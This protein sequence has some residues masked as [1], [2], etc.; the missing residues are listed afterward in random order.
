MVLT[1]IVPALCFG[2]WDRFELDNGVVS[3]GLSRE[4]AAWAIF[5]IGQPMIF[6]YYVWLPSA[7][8]GLIKD[9]V[10]RRRLPVD[11]KLVEILQD[12]QNWLNSPWL[13]RI[14]LTI[15]ILVQ[16]FV[17]LLEKGVIGSY[18]A[19][20]V[21]VNPPV[22]WSRTAIAVAVYSALAVLIFSWAILINTI[23]R[24]MRTDRVIVEPFHHDGA[25]GLGAIG[26]FV[27]NHTYFAFSMGVVLVALSL[28][29]AMAW[30][31]N[32]SGWFIGTF[33][34]A[35]IYLIVAP[36]FFLLPLFA[37]HKA[38]VRYRDGLLRGISKDMHVVYAEIRA[39][40]GERTKQ[41]ERRLVRLRQLDEL[42]QF[43]LRCPTWPFTIG[44]FRKYYAGV[45]SPV[46]AFLIGVLVEWVATYFQ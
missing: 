40:R 28:Q 25:G 30:S 38:M 4:P 12:G 32:N 20:W 41:M 13:S 6:A 31:P 24:I 1:N 17:V 10:D 21:N 46:I 26:R 18:T 2:A 35:A 23:G 42:R 43:T 33:F 7:G 36:V 29:S 3:G 14:A 9:L 37:T 44:N 19:T 22:F 15:G 5:F 16:G 27:A 45:S 8:D 39:M 34:A 11:E